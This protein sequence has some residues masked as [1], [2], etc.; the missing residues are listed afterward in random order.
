MV[1]RAKQGK[2]QPLLSHNWY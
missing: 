1:H 2:Q